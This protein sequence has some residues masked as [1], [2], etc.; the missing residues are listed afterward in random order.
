MNDVK[1]I[2][3]KA[4][5]KYYGKLDKPDIKIFVSHRIDMDCITIDTPLYIPVRSGA[6]FDLRRNTT[7]VGDDTGENI[8][9]KNRAYCEI[10][11]QYWAWKNIEA[12]YYGLCHYRRFFNFSPR[13]FVKDEFGL[14]QEE[15]LNEDTAKIYGQNEETMRAVIEKYDLIIPDPV[16]LPNL[17]SHPQSVR[18]HWAQADA[19]RNEDLELLLDAVAQLCP[20]YYQIAQNYLNG[21]IAY[22]CNLFIMKRELFYDY[23]SWLFPILEKLEEDIDIE[24]YSVEG[25]RIIGHLAER[26]L[27]IYIIYQKTYNHSLRIKEL[28]MV[29]F[30]H[31]E[32]PITV[33]PSAFPQVEKSK[34][35]PIVFAAN[36]AFAPVSAVAIR[37]VIQHANHENYYDIIIMETDIPTTSK[38]LIISMVEG[39][40]NISIRFCNVLPLIRGHNLVAHE[41][42]SVETYYRFLIQDLLPEYDKVL[43]LDGDLVCNHDVAELFAVDIDGCFLGAVYDADMSGQINMEPETLRYLIRELKMEDPFS[44]FQAGVLLLNTKE[45]KLAYSLEQWLTFASKHYRYMDQDVLNRYC[46]G[47]VKYLD[48]AWNLIIDCDNYRVPVII[49]NAKASVNRQ[50]HEARKH[51]YIVHFAGFQKPWKQRGVDF[52]SEF[53]KYARMTPF[54]EQFIFNMGVPSTP[55]N[56]NGLPPIGVRGALKIWIKK[57]TDKWMPK[58]TKRRAI[59]GRV[60]GPLVRRL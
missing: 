59:L 22:F 41:H 45:M 3:D 39:M 47:R 58:G 35:V 51:P 31:T 2:P 6:V 28:Q 43:Y 36:A 18:E 9:A 34:V 25:Q 53:W 56:N 17:P 5:L 49:R 14:V 20:E 13:R 21:D 60:F 46:Q 44:Y 24:N 23:C 12:D 26:L 19:L 7:M 10:T 8:S 55:V 32:K 30:Q 4:S 57:K 52:E 1:Q 48:M 33:L 37:S 50:Y 29:L 11:M 15:Y 38:K 54:Y 42:I 16:R 40:E 27:G